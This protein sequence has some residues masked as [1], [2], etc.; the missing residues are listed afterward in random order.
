MDSICLSYRRIAQTLSLPQISNKIVNR[1]MLARSRERKSI[2]M[3]IHIHG[4]DTFLIMSKHQAT[5]FLNAF[6][7]PLF[8]YKNLSLFFKKK[9]QFFIECQWNEGDFKAQNRWCRL[10]FALLLFCF[11]LF[12]PSN[13][14]IELKLYFFFVC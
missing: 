3:H 7:L 10:K 12:D 8:S 4:Y 9:I 6:C 1:K 2:H 14:S 5:H 13:Y 11:C